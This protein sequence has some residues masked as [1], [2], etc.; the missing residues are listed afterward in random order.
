[1]N[2]FNN[3]KKIV[4]NLITFY[5]LEFRYKKYKKGETIFKIGDVSDNF[6]SILLG[7]VDLLKLLPKIVNMTGQEYFYYLLDLIKK[8]ENY[9]YKLCITTNNKIYPI[10]IEDE[11]ILPYI[12][13]YYVIKEIYEGKQYN[14]LNELFKFLDISPKEIGLEENKLLTMDYINDNYKLIKKRFP[15]IPEDKINDYRFINNKVINRPVKIFD[16]NKFLSLESLDYFGDNSIENNTTRNGT[17]ICTEDTEVLYLN[18]KLYLNNVLTKKAIIIERKTAFLSQNYLFN[19]IPQKKFEKRYFSWFILETYNKGE[20]LFKEN[21]K[22]KYVY[23]I[24]EGN[25]KLLTSKSMLE[26][27]IMINE[28]SKKI[29]KIQSIYKNIDDENENHNLNYNNIK[30]DYQELSEHIN[31]KEI[32]QLFI[33]KE[34]EEIGIESYFLGLNNLNTCIVDSI[35]AQIYKIDIKYL[36]ELFNNEKICFYELIDRVENKLKLYRK[37]LFEINNIKLSM[38]DQKISEKKSNIYDEEFN[39]N[40]NITSFSPNNKVDLNFNKLKEIVSNKNNINNIKIDNYKFHRSSI[41][42]LTLPNLSNNKSNKSSLSKNIYDSYLNLSK[43]KNKKGKKIGNLKTS[44]Y[45]TNSSYNKTDSNSKMNTNYKT[46]N[47]IFFNSNIKSK[48]SDEKEMIKNLKKKQKRFLYEDE[49]LS[50]LKKDFNNV[51]KE[52]LMFIKPTEKK[53]VNKGISTKSFSQEN[54]Q[55]NNTIS[56]SQKNVETMTNMAA[57]SSENNNNMEWNTRRLLLTHVDNFQKMESNNKF[58]LTENTF[59]I[60][61]NNLASK[62]MLNRNRTFSNQPDL[63]NLTKTS[64]TNLSKKIELKE[65]NS[66]NKKEIILQK[67]NQLSDN[68][69]SA[70]KTQYNLNGS[71]SLNKNKKINHSYRAPLTLIKLTKYKMIAEK[72]KFIEDKKRFEMNQKINYRIRGLNSFGYPMYY[73]KRLFRPCNSDKTKI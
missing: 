71:K 49:F 9:R 37:R 53:F 22:L 8:K 44:F 25:V 51:L 64:I 57:E 30:A 45:N 29:I 1:M 60:K 72:D 47:S 24:K 55:I 54:F 70:K 41:F 11:D 6:Y 58:M 2:E 56:L 27:E 14:N 33:L 43:N 32:I 20:I 65:E 46:R 42:S 59:N 17:T 36:T 4:E 34:K 62:E 15:K 23:F 68:N 19:K 21:D 63:M 13:L 73:N 7:K 69:I 16:Y 61:K 26:L 38:T 3:D 10:Y 40:I 35:S 48:L 18:S 52:K 67:I 50:I 28:I 31:K 12:Y 39:V 66:Y 5:G